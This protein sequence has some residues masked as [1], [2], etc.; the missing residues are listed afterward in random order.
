MKKLNKAIFLDRDGTLI[1]EKH[2][3]N[4]PEKIK[5]FA[6]VVPA[7]KTLQRQGWKLI[8]GTNQAGIAR[9]Y[10]TI[11]SLH[12]IHDKLLKIFERGGVKI[13]AIYF[14]PHHPNLCCNCRKPQ[15]GMIRQ[16][17]KKFNLN[18]RECFVIGDNAS[19]I[20]WGKNVGAKTALVLTGYGKRTKKESKVK[21]DIIARS[22]PFAVKKI[23][24]QDCTVA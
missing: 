16:A 9:G 3:L 20:L 14:C 2:Y 21:P 22:L 6:G 24:W 13:D 19:D 4:D 10:V 12:A 23:L 7:L 15:S 18:L 8:I 1:Y 5:L 17:Q 11:K